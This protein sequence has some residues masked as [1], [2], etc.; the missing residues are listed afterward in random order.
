MK[1]TAEK[2]GLASAA[3]AAAPPKAQPAPRV[4][5]AVERH[6]PESSN[7]FLPATGSEAPAHSKSEGQGAQAAAG[8]ERERN[9]RQE[10]P[11]WAEIR[12]RRNK[13]RRQSDR[14][15]SRRRS[16]SARGRKTSPQRKVPRRRSRSGSPQRKR[17]SAFSSA[18]PEKANASAD[19]GAS[20]AGKSNNKFS[21]KAGVQLDNKQV[22]DW[23]K[24][25]AEPQIPRALLGRKI[26]RMPDAYIKCLIGRGGETIRHITNKTGADIRIEP[27]RENLDGIV[28]IA[29]NIEAAE[30]MIKETLAS[31]GCHWE[32]QETADLG[33]TLTNV[34]WKGRVDDSDLQI[35]TELVGLFIGNAGAGIKDIKRMVGGGVTIKILPQVM[36][37][38]FQCIQV[39]GE[40]WQRARA[41]VAAKLKDILQTTPG[42]WHQ[43]GFNAANPNVGGG[44]VSAGGGNAPAFGGYM[45]GFASTPGLS[46]SRESQREG[47]TMN[48]AQGTLST[49]MSI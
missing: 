7:L 45:P 38:G 13:E 40:Q 10:E 47:R 46:I 1:K 23:L 27:N 11:G 22:P 42:R 41:L 30:Q 35:P 5:S 19:S 29:N 32:T 33:G 3:V 28:S 15:R 17:P 16:R 6:L 37:G 4:S 36:P 9:Y 26:L 24:D 8:R 25:L 21:D 48:V 34:G 14:S 43:P 44:N 31:K 20:D 49:G 18:A 2:S 12:E 39:V